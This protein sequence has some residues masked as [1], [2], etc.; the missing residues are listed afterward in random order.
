M[1]KRRARRLNNIFIGPFAVV[2]YY[3]LCHAVCPPPKDWHR[4]GLCMLPL[5]TGKVLWKRHELENIPK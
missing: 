2:I 1:N 3:L 5:E 4:L